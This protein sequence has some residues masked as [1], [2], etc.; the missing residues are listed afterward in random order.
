MENNT[1]SK[2]RQFLPYI[3][4][5]LLLVATVMMFSN[6]TAAEKT[7]LQYYEVVA[8]FENDQVAEY[9]LNLSSGALKYRLR[10]EE[11][12]KNYKTYTVPNVSMFIGDI[13]EHVKEYNETASEA[14]KIK[15]DYQ[16]GSGNSWWMSLLP[17][18]MF[19]VILGVAMFIMTRRMSATIASENNRSISFGKARIRN[20]K[21]E[22]RRTT[23][24]DVAGADEEK[25]ELQEIVDLL[26]DP[27]KYNVLGA[28]I[29]KGV[30]L[31]G[32][33][34]TGKTLLARAVA[35]EADVPF[36]SI[37]GSDFLEMYVGV[38]A[39]RVRDLFDQA[40]KNAPSIIFIDEID[41]VGRHRGAGMGGG[42]DEREQTLNQMLVEM[43]GFGFNEGVVVIAATNRP[44]ILDPALLRPGRFDR[45]VTVSYPDVKGRTEILKVHA[46]RPYK[47]LAPDVK[48]EDIAKQTVGFTGADLENLLNEAAL[49]AARRNLKAITMKE[50]EEATMKVIVG[51]EK[52]ST[53]R[54]EEDK[55]ITAYHEAGHAIATYFQPGQDPVSHVSIIPRGMAAGFT[56]SRPE[57]DKL[58]L[59]KKHMQED[60]V[61]L[62]GG[63]VAE[64]LTQGDIC[65][66]ASNDI[67]RA[68]DMAR[69]MV[70]K[71]GM[72]DSIGPV[73]YGGG[74]HEVFLGKDY[75][76]I[77][78][79]SE[80]TAAEIDAE[81]NRIITEAY[82]RCEQILKEH[83][84]K[85][86]ELAEYLIEYEKIDGEDFEKLMQGTLN[87][88]P[89]Q[90]A[91]TDADGDTD[92]NADGDAAAGLP[93]DADGGAGETLDPSKGGDV[94]PGLPPEPPAE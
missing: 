15:F 78:N 22:K 9:S 5:P 45:Q 6:R 70:T 60:L 76:S 29:P 86:V 13:H 26:R 85:L 53:K 17:S 93:T 89:A 24:E 58:H 44:D 66:G 83:M 37:S 11:D 51:T 7:K 94:L 40:K 33:P 64:A 4:I 41:A 63:R 79:Y 34:G 46:K 30:L 73:N 10:G 84:D 62:L 56:L 14:N 8:L 35:G 19:V 39:A 18:L 25:A 32:P 61:I 69:S 27:Q 92:E 3:M 1:G 72:S 77:R 38:G 57:Q 2:L 82:S 12:E 81:V 28:R 31:V 80:A 42:H 23:F 48:L 88:T 43:D 47:P 50:I 87:P 75:G 74:D 65:T 21:D 67:E 49:L 55:R 59:S 91:Q 36:F 20:G 16:P 52:K 90:E 54:T 71:Y 68:T